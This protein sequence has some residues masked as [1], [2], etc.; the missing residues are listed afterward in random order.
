VTS[1]FPLLKE[2]FKWNQPVYTLNGKD[3]AYIRS[4]QAGANFGLTNAVQ[5]DDPEGLLEGTGKD[6]RH[7]K[8]V[9][10]NSLDLNY[11]KRLIIQSLSQLES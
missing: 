9:N 2:E 10:P 1:D 7:V 6:M 3:I 8:V 5:L 11:V 4:T